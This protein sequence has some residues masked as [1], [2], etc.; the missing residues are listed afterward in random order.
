[1]ERLILDVSS[2]SILVRT[3]EQEK[4]DKVMVGGTKLVHGN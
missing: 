2:N 4:G 3:K 1:M